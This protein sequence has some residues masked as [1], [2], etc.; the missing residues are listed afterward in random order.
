MKIQNRILVLLSTIAL[1]CILWSCDPFNTVKPTYPLQVEITLPIAVDSMHTMEFKSLTIV[2][3]DLNMGSKHT[4]SWQDSSVFDTTHIRTLLQLSAGYYDID[5]S[6]LLSLDS[7]DISLRAYYRNLVLEP[8][9]DSSAISM[10]ASVVQERNTDFVL[11][12]IFTAGTQTNEGKRYLGDS[13]FV[14]YNNTDTVLYADGLILLES[15]LKNTLKFGNLTPDFIPDYFGADAIYR[16]PGSGTDYPVPSHGIILIV[17]NA[18]NHQAA[19]ANSFDLSAAS[20]EWYDQSTSA[21]V[22]DI[23]NP[24]VP[25][26]QKIYCYTR[27]LWIPNRQGNTSFALGRIP[28]GITDSAYLIDYRCDY[29]YLLIT[30]AGT[31]SMSNTCYLFPNEWVVDCVNQCPHSS[32]QWLAVTPALDAG[33]TYIGET[34]SDKASIGKSVRRRY[35]TGNSSHFLQDTN[36]STLDFL[37]QQQAD[38]FYFLK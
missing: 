8:Q 4:C 6:I 13:Y 18:Q 28:E 33:W 14:L 23:D 30:N 10:V 11:A 16:I 17:D 21:S 34:G 2:C 36:N 12:E 3:T 37:P 15:K 1:P 20:F 22:T 35:A 38:P 27:T 24:D 32:Y 9:A 7:T 26:L 29:N 25:N 31:Y 5:A 19:N